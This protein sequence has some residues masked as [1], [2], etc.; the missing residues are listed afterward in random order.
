MKH[1]EDELQKSCVRW[2][3][4]Q[5]SEYRSLL[6]HS[7]NGGKRNAAE[8]RKFK[9]MGT[10]AGYPDLVLNVANL[11][12]HGLFVELKSAKGVQQPTQKLMEEQLVRQGY[13]YELC[14]N[15]E[16]FVKIITNYLN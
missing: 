2:F 9:E 12:Y 4:M 1:E 6:H 13:R 14:R 15:L 7:P 8:G 16:E 3:E 5:Y 11:N 10:K